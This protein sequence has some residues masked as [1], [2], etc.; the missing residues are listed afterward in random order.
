MLPTQK[1]SPKVSL[2]DLTVLLYGPTKA[3]K[4][5]SGDTVLVNATSGWPITLRDLVARQDGTVLTMRDAGMLGPQRPAAYLAHE[6]VQLYRLTTYTG[7]TIEATAEHPFLTRDGWKPLSTLRPSDAVAVVAE[8]PQLFGRGDTDADLIKLLAYLTANGTSGDGTA[9]SIDDPEVRGDFEAAVSA[10]GDECVTTSDDSGVA[11]LRVR[12]RS[13]VRSAVLAHLA[14]AGVDGVCA[15]DKVVPDFVF[16]LKK[17]RLR[18]YLN[19]LFTCDG[20]VETSGRITYRTTS[21]HMARQ[22]QHLLA[23]FGIVSL[24]RGLECDG[25]LEAVEQHGILEAVDLLITTKADVLRFIDDIGFIGEKARHAESV[26]AALYQVRVIDPPPDRLGPILFDRVFVIEPTQ[27]AP[28]YDLTI[29]DSHNFVANDFIVH[30]STWCA[31][32]DGALFLATEPGLNHLEV[33]QQPIGTWDE[34]LVAARELADGKHAFRTVIIDTVDNAYRMCAEYVCQRFKIEHESDLEYGKGYA[35]VNGEFHRVLNKLAL[36]PYG[37]F[38]VSHSQDKEIE[39][40]TGKFT[41]VVPTLPDKARKLVLGLV[42][43]ILFCD[44]EPTTR[45]DGKP[46]YR[47]V[48]RTKPS[49]TYEAGDRTGRLP[50]VIELDFAAFVAAFA[51][52]APRA[53]AA[54]TTATSARSPG[55]SASAASAPVSASNSAPTTSS[56]PGTPASSAA[57]AAKPSPAPAATPSA[58]TANSPRANTRATPPTSTSAASRP[59]TTSTTR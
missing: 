43:I 51:Q 12:G 23:R 48:L 27:I 31:Q 50:E 46:T 44:F 55:A 45:P 42:D 15:P 38:L 30:N 32:A 57:A 39:T 8:Y 6:P 36:L 53:E 24:L 33:F 16:G 56:A 11:R 35:L 22:V 18:L 54:G 58:P 52:G 1:T 10:K 25:V 2:H 14:F 7:R 37:L 5:L 20:T 9:P 47:R 59:R 41:K 28:V 4:C 34:L 17:D 40:R 13:G 49:A 21:V 19:R 29:D 3:G 26:R